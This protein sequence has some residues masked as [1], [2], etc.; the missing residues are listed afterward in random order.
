MADIIDNYE[1]LLHGGI[2]VDEASNALAP[3]TE[4]R[5]VYTDGQVQ[6]VLDVAERAMRRAMTMIRRGADHAVRRGAYLTAAEDYRKLGALSGSL[7][8]FGGES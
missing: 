8:I 7:S 4:Y 3:W 5:D 1:K 2:D 6:A